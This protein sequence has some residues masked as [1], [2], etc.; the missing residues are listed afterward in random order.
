[1][2]KGRRGEEGSGEERREGYREGYREGGIDPCHQT[3]LR[4]GSGIY[5]PGFEFSGSDN[6]S[7]SDKSDG[8]PPPENF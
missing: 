8:P 3:L 2:L 4:N 6:G 7:G 1:M 5:L